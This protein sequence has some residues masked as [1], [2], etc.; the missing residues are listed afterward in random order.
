[1][2]PVLN[3]LFFSLLLSGCM[4]PDDQT[5]ER[6]EYE[7]SSMMNTDTL[8]VDTSDELFEVSSRVDGTNVHL[9]LKTSGT[10][11][12][13][14]TE[15]EIT[16][17]VP[18]WSGTLKKTDNTHFSL[19][20]GNR[21]AADELAVYFILSSSKVIYLEKENRHINPSTPVLIKRVKVPV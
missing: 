13:V 18:D 11:D 5:N 10:F 21:F 14:I 15:S 1:M 4:I 20:R 12:Y 2:R 17:R 7:I 6:E 19:L 9:S 8:I 3:I 16:I